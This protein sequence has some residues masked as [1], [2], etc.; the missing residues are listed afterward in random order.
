[1][2]T[3]H[4][5]VHQP[6]DIMGCFRICLSLPSFIALCSQNQ[7]ARE[8]YHVTIN[9]S[10]HCPVLSYLTLTE[11]IGNLSHYLHPN[12]TLVFLSG[13][14]HL[15]NANLT[16]L[17]VEDFMIKSDNSIARIKYIYK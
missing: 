13:T 4:K 11:F 5:A 17:N 2:Q 8:V 15:S 12:T 6:D 16:L 14:H 1:M 7:T 3:N 9:S 10:D